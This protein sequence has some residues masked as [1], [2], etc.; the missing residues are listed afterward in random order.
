MSS[1]MSGYLRRRPGRVGARAQARHSAAAGA[2]RRGCHKEAAAL[3]PWT[4]VAGAYPVY[5]VS[6]ASCL[7]SPGRDW[8]VLF[9]INCETLQPLLITCAI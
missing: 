1:R 6:Y 4:T 2:P 7:Q 8:A 3:D 9:F 5:V